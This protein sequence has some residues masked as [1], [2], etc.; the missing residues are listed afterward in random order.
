MNLSFT[1]TCNTIFALPKYCHLV[2]TAF[3][4]RWYVSYPATPKHPVQI[5]LI[6]YFDFFCLINLH[7]DLDSMQSCL[8][9]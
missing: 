9:A 1:R 7:V 8:Y 2:A 5:V 4:S 6:L 3:S